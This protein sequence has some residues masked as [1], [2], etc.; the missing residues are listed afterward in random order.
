MS[1]ETD[2]L[3]NQWDNFKKLLNFL[4]TYICNVG[5]G[6]TPKLYAIQVSPTAHPESTGSYQVNLTGINGS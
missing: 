2:F 4:D 3:T 1:L 5:W 6:G